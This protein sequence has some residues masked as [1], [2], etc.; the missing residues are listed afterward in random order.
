MFEHVNEVSILVSALLAVAIGNIWYSPV[1]FGPLWMRSLGKRTGEDV[2]LPR[3][4]ITAVL[5]GIASYSIFFYVIASTMSV[6]ASSDYTLREFAAAVAL[7][8][9]MPLVSIVA[10][11]KKPFEYF[12]IHAGFIAV[13]TMIGISVI[14][15]WPW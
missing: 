1:V 14:T 10:W 5:K 6:L 12:A 15:Y 3:E 9:I 13:V 7:L 11:E 8:A 4:V 2:F